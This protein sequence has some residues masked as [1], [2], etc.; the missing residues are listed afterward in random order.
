MGWTLVGWRV[1]VHRCRFRQLKY[2]VSG[3]LVLHLTYGA[4]SMRADGKCQECNP[5][6]VYAG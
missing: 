1:C 3:S 6:L 5:Y 4:L 2:S